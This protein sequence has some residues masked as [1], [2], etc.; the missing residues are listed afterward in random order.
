[1]LQSCLNL[2]FFPIFVHCFEL[3]VLY[4]EGEILYLNVQL[5]MDEEDEIDAM[6]HQDGGGCVGK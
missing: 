6:W 1:M 4:D 5:N 3:H 2:F